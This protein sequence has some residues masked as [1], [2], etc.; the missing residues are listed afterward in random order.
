MTD[1]SRILDQLPSQQ[2]KSRLP[3]VLLLDTSHS[4][5]LTGGITQLNDALAAWQRQLQDEDFIARVG[6]IAMV[7]FGLGGVRV[8]DATGQIEEEPEEPF[9]SVAAFDPPQLQ[10]GGPTPMV[11]G[12]E[13]A[14]DLVRE[15]K[16]E[17]RSQGLILANRPLVY[18]ITDGGPTDERG[19][20]TSS[21]KKLAPKLR[22]LEQGKH[23]LFFA[24]GVDGADET[25]LEG[26]A[27]E[28]AHMLA[29]LQFSQ[30]LRFVS[31][32]V[33]TLSKAGTS[34]QSASEAYAE[35]EEQQAKHQRV[36]DWL[37]DK[38]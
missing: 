24:F 6:E 27:P 21:W 12:I 36:A 16:R 3:I 13:R 5:E 38:A 28:S 29:G 37:K 14:I 19:K 2:A 20:L 10:A 31:A 26:L 25:V 33:E 4:M 17:L 9:V 23:L 8:V 18:M 22:D 35:I 30:F 7:T 34:D 32:S 1:A 15:R 11:E